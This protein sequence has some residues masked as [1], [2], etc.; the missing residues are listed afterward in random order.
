[1]DYKGPPVLGRH[2]FQHAMPIGGALKP[3][4]VS[5]RLTSKLEHR[6]HS[7]FLPTI[8]FLKPTVRVP[9]AVIET[10]CTE[11]RRKRAA[12]A[13][14]KRLGSLVAITCPRVFKKK[15]E[16][17]NGTTA[18][19]MHVFFFQDPFLNDLVQGW[20]S[21]GGPFTGGSPSLV[22]GLKRW[23]TWDLLWLRTM[24]W[25]IAD[26]SGNNWWGNSVFLFLR[27]SCQLMC[28]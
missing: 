17:K 24:S 26:K 19:S 18:R 6:E 4:R 22:D 10:W 8:G 2:A 1:M 9:V 23:Q 5:W 3:G 13:G 15:K 14:A 16:K 28:V 21:T 25:D 20:V 11:W 7:V 27:I 12:M